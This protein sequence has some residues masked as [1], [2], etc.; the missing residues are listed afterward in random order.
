MI[1]KQG[2]EGDTSKKLITNNCVNT[3]NH[4][5]GNFTFESINKKRSYELGAKHRLFFLMFWKI[6]IFLK[7]IIDFQLI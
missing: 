6:K 4:S 3:I 1:E 2:K 7:F 5:N